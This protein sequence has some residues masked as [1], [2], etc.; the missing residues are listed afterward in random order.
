MDVIRKALPVTEGEFAL[1]IRELQQSVN[2]GTST[3]T[4]SGAHHRIRKR[5]RH[6]NH[7][8]PHKAKQEILPSAPNQ[9]T[10]QPTIELG[11]IQAEQS[12]QDQEHAVTNNQAKLPTAPAWN[13][14]FQQPE[15]FREEFTVNL[16]FVAWSVTGTIAEAAGS[17]SSPQLDLALGGGFLLRYSIMNA[18]QQGC[19][20]S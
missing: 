4:R 17:R 3:S 13:N 14:N 6:S 10:D 7:H 9:I 20:K 15:Q 18:L 19:K 16:D 2:F 12:S 11:N 5:R 1:V 8:P